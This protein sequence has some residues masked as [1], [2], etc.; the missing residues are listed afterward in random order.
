MDRRNSLH[1]RRRLCVAA[2]RAL[3][4]WASAWNSQRSAPRA[5]STRAP[6][7]S[8]SPARAPRDRRRASAAHSSRSATTACASRPCRPTRTRPAVSPTSGVG[9]PCTR[10]T[11]HTA[12]CRRTSSSCRQRGPR[13]KRELGTGG[14]GYEAEHSPMSPGSRAAPQRHG[15][16]TH[17]CRQLTQ[18]WLTFCR[19]RLCARSSPELGMAAVDGGMSVE[20]RCVVVEWR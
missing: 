13:A 12:G 18:A 9:A 2:A 5:V 10:H 7:A 17:L 14:R 16:R 6:T 15:R 19:E 8:C 3:A 20:R 11:S 1:P 4:A